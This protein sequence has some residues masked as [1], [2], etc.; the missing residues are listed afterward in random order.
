[1]SDLKDAL[2][3]IAKLG[4]P[5]GMAF[6]KVLTVDADAALCSVELLSDADIVLQDV[7]LTATEQVVGW[8]PV[9]A[10]GS[11]VM[12]DTVNNVVVLT[13]ELQEA[14]I[15]VENSLFC[16]SAQGLLLQRQSET[17]RACLSDLCQAIA[18]ITVPVTSAPGT[19]GVP[20]N[21]ATFVSIRTRLES[22]LRAAV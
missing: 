18:Q 16:V 19:S 12:V 11:F 10:E 14:R 22:I 5:Q 3:Q 9:P 15:K 17:L 7:Q 6:A 1:M 8:E 20:V 21:A 4:T 2:M 13:S